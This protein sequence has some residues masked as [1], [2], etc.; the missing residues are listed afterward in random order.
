[1]RLAISVRCF[2]DQEHVAE[3]GRQFGTA[4]HRDPGHRVF[5]RASRASNRA[6][7]FRINTSNTRASAAPHA[8]PS[9]SAVEAVPE[10]LPSWS[11]TSIG[12]VAWSPEN[13]S[14]LIDAV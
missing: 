6:P 14:K 4:G 5:G 13:G 1:M 3:C 7:T 11:Q 2:L 10:R 12:R 8:R 9:V